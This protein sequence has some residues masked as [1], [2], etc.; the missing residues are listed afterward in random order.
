MAKLQ[1]SER[2]TK[3]A[4]EEERQQ[5]LTNKLEKSQQGI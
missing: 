2:Q 5:K 4:A 1:E 3:R